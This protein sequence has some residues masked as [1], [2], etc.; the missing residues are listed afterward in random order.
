[1]RLLAWAGNGLGRRGLSHALGRQA[2][3]LDLVPGGDAG[4]P[5]HEGP[6]RLREGSVCVRRARYTRQLPASFSKSAAIA[7]SRPS[8]SI[9]G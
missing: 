3:F 5:G 4:H 8:Q 1:M 6:Q 9:T 2:G 7:S